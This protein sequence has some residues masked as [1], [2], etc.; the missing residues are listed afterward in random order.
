MPY[1]ATVF[2]IL[3]A[4]PSDVEDE[5]SVVVQ[6]IQEWND[7]H[8]A[9]RKVVLLP[10]RWETHSHPEYGKRP[11]EIVNTQVVDH[12]DLLIGIFWT[13]IGTSTGS[14]SSGTIEEIERTAKAGKP[15]MLYFS[16]AKVDLDKIDTVQLTQLKE[17]QK[18]TYPNALVDQYN[19]TVD[20]RD[21]LSRHLEMRVREFISGTSGGESVS[22]VTHPTDV[23]LNILDVESGNVLG[24][25][26]KWSGEILN[27]DA[28]SSIPDY[29]TAPQE[30]KKGILD[31]LSFN[32]TNKNYYREMILR[33]F[34]A[35]LLQPLQISMEN[36]GVIGVRDVFI[37]VEL[38][39][40]KGELYF[41]SHDMIIRKPEKSYDPF[42]F[43]R[44]KVNM[45]RILAKSKSWKTTIELSGIQPKR[46]IKSDVLGYLGATETTTIQISAVVYGDCF[47]E[48]RRK[49]LSIDFSVNPTTI[50]IPSI[51]KRLE[52]D[53]PVKPQK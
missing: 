20:F 43:N 52:S 45:D 26:A 7:L 14:S 19:T 25:S 37:D 6:C 40:A 44:D 31:G 34:Q 22:T 3:I 28:F 9:D 51:M 49:T 11:Q 36:T 13:R 24:T 32:T 8:S 42:P 35:A 15:V 27:M 38:S 10:L 30:A 12:C 17:F 46:T 16:K 23:V 18:N 53:T 5:R 50:D 47:A 21:K 1:Q 39:T 33:V 4:S 48:P 41:I 2:R 29:A